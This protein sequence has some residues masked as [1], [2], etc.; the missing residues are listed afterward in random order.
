IPYPSMAAFD[1]PSRETCTVRRVRTN[2][3]LQAFVTLNDPVYVEAAQALARRIVKEGGATA[4]DQARYGL[5]LALS[6]PPKP[7]QVRQVLALYEQARAKYRSDA[8]AALAL[9]TEPLG[10]LPEGLPADEAAAWTVVANVLLNLDGVLM[11]G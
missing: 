10:P 1:A 3:P 5:T 2:T 4:E 7:E 8:K 11:K 6:R 9:A